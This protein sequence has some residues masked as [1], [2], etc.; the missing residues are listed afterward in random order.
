[1]SETLKA[2]ANLGPHAGRSSPSPWTAERI[3]LMRRLRFVEGLSAA[4]IAAALSLT[5]HTFTRN[6]VIAKCDRLGWTGQVTAKQRAQRYSQQAKLATNIRDGRAPKPRK[7][8]APKPAAEKI[9]PKP[10]REIGAPRGA[11]NLRF[12][13]TRHHVH[14]QR[15]VGDESGARGLVCGRD[16][17]PGKPWC[18]E[19]LGAVY[20][21]SATAKKA[22]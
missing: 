11:W 13:E 20:D 3:E 5:G 10:V 18:A 21:Y 16:V 4:R 2:L 1:M 8:K 14:C 17:K 6:S 7:P 22:A 12:D 9:E 19:C 15:F